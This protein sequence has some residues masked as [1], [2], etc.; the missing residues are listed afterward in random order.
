MMTIPRQTI[1]LIP[2]IMTDMTMITPTDGY[3][4][5]GERECFVAMLI[6]WI[7]QLCLY[8]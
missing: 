5:V 1:P 3:P 2:W 7:W 6:S 4:L 8:C